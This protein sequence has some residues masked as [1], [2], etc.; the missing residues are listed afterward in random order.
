MTT[1]IDKNNSDNM[2]STPHKTVTHDLFETDAES[3]HSALSES[4]VQV[5]PA[6]LT[7]LRLQAQIKHKLFHWV[8][9]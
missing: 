3:L 9:P 4:S 8:C 7:P 1:G 6:S 2:E 5:L